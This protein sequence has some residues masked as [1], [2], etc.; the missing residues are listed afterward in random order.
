[1]FKHTMYKA[2]IVLALGMV[3]SPPEMIRVHRILGNKME[4][5]LVPIPIRMKRRM[6]RD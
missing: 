6:R 5:D 2:S 3:F 4:N 1:M